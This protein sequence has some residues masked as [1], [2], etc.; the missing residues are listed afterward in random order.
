MV[1]ARTK[2]AGCPKCG[3][4][5]VRGGARSACGVCGTAR[6]LTS[7][8]VRPA[9]LTA[10]SEVGAAPTGGPPWTPGVVARAAG[11][12]VVVILVIVWAV[13]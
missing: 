9:T 1:K 8:D 12:W 3:A 11:A 10:A 7:R 4:V 6:P 5:Y 13:A 2:L